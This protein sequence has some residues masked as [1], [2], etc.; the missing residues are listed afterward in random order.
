MARLTVATEIGSFRSEAASRISDYVYH[1]E[2]LT[3]D[4]VKWINQGRKFDVIFDAIGNQLDWAYPFI[5]KGG[6]IV[7]MGFDD[8]YEMTVSSTSCCQMA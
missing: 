2:A 5:E 7:P 4:E 1:P 6:R 8:T 3:V